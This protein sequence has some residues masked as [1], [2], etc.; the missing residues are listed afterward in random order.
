MRGLTEDE[1]VGMI[2]RGF[3]EGGINGLPDNL[4]DDIDRAIEKANL[5]S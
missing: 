2:V 1:A 3:L 5:G 4:K